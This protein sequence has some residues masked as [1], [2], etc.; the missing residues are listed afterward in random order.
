MKS[1]WI[2]LLTCLLS[3]S[4]VG[5]VNAQAPFQKVYNNGDESAQALNITATSDGGFAFIGIVDIAGAA[6]ELTV[7]KL[8]CRGDV[9]WVKIL[10]PSST[11]NNIFP[12]IREDDQ[13]RIWFGG[14]VGTF[15]NYD[16]VIGRLD[17]DGNLEKAIRIGN[18]GRNDQIYGI[19]LDGR[20]NLYATGST[21]SWGSDKSGSTSY[22]DVL[23]MRLDTAMNV[24]W[25]R[26]LGNPQAIDN[27][28]SIAVDSSGYPISTGRFIVPN[29][30]GD[31]TFFSYYL[32]MDPDGNVM[33]FK[34]FGEYDV[35]HRTYGYGVTATSDGAILLSGSTTILKD[36][37]QSMPDVYLIKTDLSGEPQFQTIF[38]PTLGQDRSESGS[39][40]LEMTDG[41][42]AIGVPTMSFTT[43]TQGF[44][45]NKN[46][47]F[48][49][50]TNGT[51][52]EARLY[53]NGGSHYTQLEPRPGGYVL[54][55][56][57]TQYGAPGSFKPLIIATDDSLSSGCNEINVSNELAQESG[58]WNVV[59]IN[60]QIDS[61]YNTQPYA[62][63]SDYAFQFAETL[64]ESEESLVVELLVQDTV[65]LGDTLVAVAMSNEPGVTY[66]WT[67]S[68]GDPIS[69]TDTAVLVPESAGVILINVVGEGLCGNVT[70]EREVV[71]KEAVEIIL[72]APESVC[73]GDTMVAVVSSS[74]PLTD[75]NWTFTGGTS[76]SATDTAL[77]V[78]ATQGMFQLAVTG[79]S[80]CGPVEEEQEVNVSQCDCEVEFPNMFTPN[81]DGTNDVFGA[82][83]ACDL[84][85]LTYEMQIYNRYGEMVYSTNDLATPW[86]GRFDGEAQPADMYAWVCT[87][88][89]LLDGQEVSFTRR[90][91][92]TLLR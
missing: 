84:E 32:R 20:G 36:N 59:D 72:E 13:G 87:M 21:N 70:V 48:V 51:I 85:V 53:N 22:T 35:P 63:A 30:A 41:R 10:G 1:I 71:V 49:T 77:F 88:Q 90:G 66:T 50:D 54:S 15:Q 19:A 86:D 25:A 2:P 74:D 31:G 61:Q 47:V 65:C 92:I 6:S 26:T 3:L 9:E 73:L 16:G 60:A 18:P 34:G 29:A 24:L 64:C 80:S 5:L 78:P 79:T 8:D 55:N 4:V 82:Y 27:G 45:P 68:A 58:F 62:I 37:H 46:A 42:Y 57:S 69:A 89:Y 40:V 28:F 67:F 33:A 83:V 17:A 12:S 81:S 39:S 44:V 23:T 38:Y 7:T 75:L 56:F 91:E 14:N 76:I 11:V 52:S 43:H